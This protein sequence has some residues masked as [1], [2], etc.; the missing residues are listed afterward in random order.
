MT[1]MMGVTMTEREENPGGRRVLWMC[2]CGLGIVMVMGMIAGYVGE[3][4]AAAGTP[5]DTTDIVF[6]SIFA[7]LIAALGLALWYQGRKLARACSAG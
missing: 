3:R 4:G 7:A 1:D 5:F 6:L 2:L